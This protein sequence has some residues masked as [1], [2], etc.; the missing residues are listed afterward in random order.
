MCGVR[1]PYVVPFAVSIS[2]H[3]QQP[4][5]A[6]WLVADHAV[7]RVVKVREGI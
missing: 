1:S 6:V 4:L 5:T 2:L 7:H 3:D